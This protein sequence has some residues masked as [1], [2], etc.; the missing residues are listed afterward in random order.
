LLL[1]FAVQFLPEEQKITQD[2]E[3]VLLYHFL[4]PCYWSDSRSFLFPSFPYAYFHC[5]FI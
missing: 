5:Q 3:C 1:F 4:S 2:L